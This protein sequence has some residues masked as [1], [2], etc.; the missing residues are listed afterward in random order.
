M[1]WNS[2]SPDRFPAALDRAVLPEH[3]C[4]RERY[5]IM[6]PLYASG[7]ELYYLAVDTK[8]GRECLL[9]ALVPLPWCKTDPQEGFVPYHDADAFTWEALKAK[10]FVR[11]GRLSEQSGEEAVP[12]VLE[13]FEA[14]GTLWYVA[15]LPKGEAPAPGSYSPKEAI[16]CM[17]PVMDT[18]AGLHEQ[19]LCHGAVSC[20][21][22][23]FSEGSAALYDWNSWTCEEYGEPGIHADV[24]GVARVLYTMM[25][26]EESYH[27]RTA[28]ALPKSVAH[29][30]WNGMHDESLDMEGLWKQLH[31]RR[32]ARCV[33]EAGTP[34]TGARLGWLIPVT[35]VF[36]VLCL[37]LPVLLRT[38]LTG[39]DPMPDAVYALEAEEIRVPELLYMTQEDASAAAEALGLH[40]ILTQRAN[41]PAVPEGGILT[42][43]PPSGAIRH[44]GDTVTLTVSSGWANFVPNVTDLLLEEAQE[45]L[46]ERG[47]SVTYEE[48]PSIDAAPGT[49]IRQSVRPDVKIGLDTVIHLTVSLGRE[50]LDTSKLE[51]VDNYVGMNFADAKKA[52]SELYLYALQAQTVYDPDTP[53]GVILSQDVRPGEAVPQG[54]VIRMAVSLGEE[55]THVPSVVMMGAGS[56]RQ[57]LIDAK[58]KPVLVYVPNGDYVMDCVLAQGT[59]PDT[60]LGVNSEVWLT[61]SVG[62][63]SYVVS[64]GGWSGNPLPEFATEDETGDPT[65]GETADETQELTVPDATDAD[66]T[67]PA[68]TDPV[69]SEILPPQPDTEPETQ[70]QTLVLPPEPET[71]VLPELPPET[72]APPEPETLPPEVPEETFAHEVPDT[73][74]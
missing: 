56:A 8:E 23:R 51:T 17:A 7:M 11:L 71:E 54:T 29:A 68:M 42:Q 49:V 6:H 9:C 59:E 40:V 58:L 24:R 43:D 38:Q 69:Q 74:P 3:T 70:E 2:T 22:L 14:L 47:F 12:Q 16:A 55:T 48:I 66:V 1:I 13:V 72:L 52:L 20:Q 4:L 25:T 35:A 21:A 65:Q 41:N 27:R 62:S 53:A 36:C 10:C 73:D 61:V 67:E 45:R 26:G 44:P 15:P 33:R 18:L 28:K 19:G 30:L 57:A 50:D 64:T 46:S 39:A 5:V 60:V 63:A 31:A 37:L 34:R 32:P